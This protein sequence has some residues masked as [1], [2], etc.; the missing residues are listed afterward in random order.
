MLTVVDERSEINYFKLLIKSCVILLP[1]TIYY[2]L[3]AIRQAHPKNDLIN[4]A[5]KLLTTGYHI[6]VYFE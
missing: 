3:C 4:F 2:G 6:W 5:V 1:A